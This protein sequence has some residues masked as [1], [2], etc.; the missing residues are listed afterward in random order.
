VSVGDLRVGLVSACAPHVQDLVIAGHDRDEIA[1][2]LFTAPGL[3]PAVASSARDVVREALRTHN[4]AHPGS[5]TRVGRALFLPEP[6]SIDRGEI[7]DKGYLNQRAVLSCRA[8][9]VERLYASEPDP[10]V[11]IVD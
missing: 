1:V 11:V 7:T 4:R 9:E 6:P 5:S 3:D 2:L 8:A 10:E